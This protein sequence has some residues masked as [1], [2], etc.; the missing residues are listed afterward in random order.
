MAGLQSM[1]RELGRLHDAIYY[2]FTFNAKKKSQLT[3]LFTKLYFDSHVAGETFLDT[4]WL[5][6]PTYKCPTDLWV[7]QELVFEL[8][9]EIIIETGTLFGGSAY[10][11]AS[12]CDLIYS[13]RVITIDIDDAPKGH[14][15][16]KAIVSQVRPN[17]SRITYLLGSSVAETILNKVRELTR[18]AKKIL[19]ILDSDHSSDHV[20]SELRAY[21][22]LV[23]V[24]SYII[25][26]DTIANGHP[27]LPGFGPGPMEAAEEFLKENHSF[28]IDRSREKHL[29]TF[30]PRGYLKKIRSGS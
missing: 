15:R 14:P 18:D 12:L 5:G 25:V 2:R 20:L 24:G 26:E 13:G 6:V 11:L 4:S 23:S 3:E 9:P 8:R 21:A 19:V 7:Y 27:V 16:Q 30:N 1:K 17:H 10:Y 28:T 29:L 22:P